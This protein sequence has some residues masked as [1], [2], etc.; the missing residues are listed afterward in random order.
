MSV[1]RFISTGFW[2]DRWVRTLDPSEKYLYLYLL[3]NPLTT[4]AGIY[5]ITLDRMAFDTGYDERTLLPMLDRFARAGKA[6]FKGNEWV[7][8]PAWPAHQ[9]WESR[10]N[11]RSGIEAILSDLSAEMLS[12]LVEVGYRFESPML[13]RGVLP[14]R[15]GVPPGGTR[16]NP[17][18]SRYSD[19]DS[20]TDTDSDSDSDVRKPPEVIH[21]LALLAADLASKNPGLLDEARPYLEAVGHQ[22]ERSDPWR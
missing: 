15:E 14:G 13:P 17:E 22:A 1:Q 18:E 5:K 16:R 3:T 8:L 9:K 19:S 10:K 20:D 11:I 12:F 7:I 21:K 2:E 6:Y 4:I